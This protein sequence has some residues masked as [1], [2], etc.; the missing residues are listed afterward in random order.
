[1]EPTKHAKF[2]I[3]KNDDTDQFVRLD[4]GSDSYV[5]VDALEASKFDTVEQAMSSGGFL[6]GYN[7]IVEMTITL[8]KENKVVNYVLDTLANLFAEEFNRA[9]PWQHHALI[10]MINR[11]TVIDLPSSITAPKV[12]ISQHRF[13][14][15]YV[16]DNKQEL[17]PDFDAFVW[18]NNE[19]GTPLPALIA[20]EDL[21]IEI[22]LKL[23]AN[24]Q[25][26]ILTL[27][28]SPEA[29]K[30]LLHSLVVSVI[31][32]SVKQ[33]MDH[34]GLVTTDVSLFLDQITETVI[35]RS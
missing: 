10:D 23:P 34:N 8:Q 7:S 24:Q 26:S 33:F 2:F 16:V 27:D 30:A 13:D 18:Y 15:R 14:L 31:G 20:N 1:M 4:N 25:G 35:A 12:I 28:Y 22:M 6:P 29:A 32:G 11:K 9:A 17:D 19:R 3:Q 21:I 5:Y